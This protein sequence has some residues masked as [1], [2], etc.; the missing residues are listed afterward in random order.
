MTQD[1]QGKVYKH[2][3]PCSLLPEPSP[4]HGGRSG[5]P[6]TR[7]ADIQF[8]VEVSVWKLTLDLAEGGCPFGQLDFPLVLN[9]AEMH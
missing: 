6:G 7:K 9:K 4:V 1:K 5:S 3:N 8:L 2:V